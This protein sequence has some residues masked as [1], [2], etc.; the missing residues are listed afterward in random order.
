MN[1]RGIGIGSASLILIFSVLCLTVFSLLTLSMANREKELSEKLRS[2]VENYY[3]SDNAAVDIAAKFRAYSKNGEY[4][5]QIN[6]VA[7]SNKGE[8]RYSYSCPIDDRRSIV[9]E[10]IGK[11]GEINILSWYETNIEKWSPDENIN[12]WMGE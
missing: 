10:F 8:D 2:S 5:F 7:I 9:V 4:P 12:V 11:D 1:R 3:S 6:D